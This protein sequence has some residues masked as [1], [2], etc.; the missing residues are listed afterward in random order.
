M[1]LEFKTYELKKESRFYK[2]IVEDSKKLNE[3]IIV[4]EEIVGNGE[5][6][7]DCF[8]AHQLD[9]IGLTLLGGLNIEETAF[10]IE[11]KDL[12]FKKDDL[13]GV[14]IQEIDIPMEYLTKKIIKNIKRLNG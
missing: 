2:M 10:L 9:D 4:G 8:K 14:E 7:L 5:K 3:F 1:N 6:A 11:K 13:P 12:Q